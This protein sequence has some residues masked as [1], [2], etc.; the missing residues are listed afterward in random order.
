MQLNRLRVSEDVDQKLRQLKSKLGL[1]PN[2]ICRLGFCL[3]LREPGIPDP[4]AYDEKSNREFNRYTLTGE[5]DS[6]FVAL[7]KQRC[8]KDGLITL[9]D[10]DD[11]FRAHLNRGVLLIYQRVKHLNDLCRLTTEIQS[12]LE[13]VI[14]SDEVQNQ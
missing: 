4:S 13:P 14:E 11:Q 1:T 5:W 9:K 8:S 2:L 10:I 12:G 3:S 6:L 7:L